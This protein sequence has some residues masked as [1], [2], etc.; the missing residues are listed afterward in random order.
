[1]LLYKLFIQFYSVFLFVY[2]IAHIIQLN[3]PLLRTVS[4][5]ETNQLVVMSQT[6]AAASSFVIATTSIAIVVLL[7]FYYVIVIN[8]NFTFNLEVVT[9]S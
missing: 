7:L 2:R 9:Q 4:T 6:S 1:M 5:A 8:H 3:D